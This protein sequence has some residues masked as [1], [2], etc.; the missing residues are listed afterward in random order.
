MSKR[1]VWLIVATALILAGSILFV[2]VMSKMNWDLTNGR[3]E[4]NTHTVTED[5]TNISIETTTADIRFA[6]SEDGTVS[7]VCYEDVNR[8]HTVSVEGDTL[9]IEEEDTRKWYQH[10]YIFSSTPKITVYL[11]ADTYGALKVKITTGDVTVPDNYS[12]ATVD[13]KATT[14]DIAFSADVAGDLTLKATT[15]DVTISSVACGDLTI[16]GTTADTTLT[17]VTCRNLTITGTTGDVMLRN[18]VGSGTFSIQLSTG[19]VTFDACD[20]ARLKVKTTT[21]DITGTLL[22]PKDF[23]AHTTTGDVSVPASGDGGKC[24]LNATTG[25]IRITIQ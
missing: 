19:E 4:T 9:V 22:T 10:M 17:N 14:G 12:F 3:Y 23:D 15:G 20:A 2:G 5:F 11:P 16:T 24:E 18:A 1:T 21:G 13:V 7:V 6:P 25:D 8:K